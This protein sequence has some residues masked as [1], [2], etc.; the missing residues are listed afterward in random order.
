LFRHALPTA[1]RAG[2][3][4]TNIDNLCTVCN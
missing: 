4:S 3:F 1:D 2:R